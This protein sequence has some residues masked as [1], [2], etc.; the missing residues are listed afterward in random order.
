MTLTSTNLL[1][2]KQATATMNTPC[3]TCSYF[4]KIMVYINRKMWAYV[5]IVLAMLL[6]F[7]VTTRKEKFSVNWM[8]QGLT[9]AVN[10]LSGSTPELT[11]S[12]LTAAIYNAAKRLPKPMSPKAKFDDIIGKDADDMYVPAFYKIQTSFPPLIK[13]QPRK[14]N[15]VG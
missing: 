5:I 7:Y 2:L 15:L 10:K 9:D 6:A 13:R 8:K 3:M 4:N 14:F 1:S 12:G 11:T